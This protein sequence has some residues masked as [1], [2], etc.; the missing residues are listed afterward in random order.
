MAYCW[1][2]T[3]GLPAMLKPGIA[4]VDPLFVINTVLVTKLLLTIALLTPD[5]LIG[6]WAD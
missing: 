2:S 4:V 3:G 6:V 5:K 1:N